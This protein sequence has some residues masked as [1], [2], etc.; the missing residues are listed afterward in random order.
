MTLLQQLIT[1][2]VA[3]LATLI[4]RFSP[5]VVFSGKKVPKAVE[6]LGR[7]L[8]GAVF[9]LLLVYCLKDLDLSSYPVGLGEALGVA[10]TAI[11]YK[12]RK[13]TLL[14]ILLGTLF[15][16]FLIQVVFV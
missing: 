12:W 16:M 14:S 10:L 5:F 9:G 8:P 7:A 6:Y 3:A 15:Y 11:I 13:N 1:I 4:T 2:L